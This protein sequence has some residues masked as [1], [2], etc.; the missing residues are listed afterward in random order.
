MFLDCILG[1][2][3]PSR[4]C[5]RWLCRFRLLWAPAPPL[6]LWYGFLLRHVFH[7]DVLLAVVLLYHRCGLLAPTH[8]RLWSGVGRFFLQGTSVILFQCLVDG[9][10]ETPV[11][12]TRRGLFNSWL[13]DLV[14]CRS[15]ACSLGGHFC[16]RRGLL[17]RL[18]CRRRSGDGECVP[19][20]TVLRV[21]VDELQQIRPGDFGL[22]HRAG[23]DAD[24]LRCRR[25]KDKGADFVRCA[26]RE[27]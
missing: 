22:G 7:V 14:G 1:R 18:L 23:V 21:R 25:K 3:F 24:Q 5:A 27:S 12:A 9:S 6:G 13:G 15:A 8:A 11:V 2:C 26:R 4:G 10:S 17:G 20:E 16:C 19:V